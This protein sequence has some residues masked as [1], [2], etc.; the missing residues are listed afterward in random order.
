VYT[1]SRSKAQAKSWHPA[2]ALVRKRIAELNRAYAA[3]F[4]TRKLPDNGLGRKWARYMMRTKR[5]YPSPHDYLWLKRWC[6]WMDQS[7]QDKIL[8]YRGHWYSTSSLGQ[9]LEID[10]DMRTSLKLWTMRPNDVA[11]EDVQ[12]ERK[13]RDY[14]KKQAKRRKNG[15]R[16]RADYEAN[17]ASAEAKAQANGNHASL[18]L[19]EGWVCR[20]CLC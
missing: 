19:A 15:M 6:P 20:A 16:T 10:N 8:G 2:P 3:F 12:L 5:L 11:W 4:P 7:E 18:S 9:H 13:E 17:S 1:D 14:M